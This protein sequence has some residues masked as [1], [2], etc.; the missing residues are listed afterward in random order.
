MCC[1]GRA[2]FAVGLVFS[3]GGIIDS[4]VRIGNALME[5]TRQDALKVFAQEVQILKGQLRFVQLPF[6]EDALDDGVNVR[7]DARGRRIV[8]RAAG[9]LNGVGQH[10]DG[11]F[12]GLRAR[13]HIAEIG[14][15]RLFALVQGLLVEKAYQPCAVVLTD[16]VGNILPELVPLG[17]FRAFFDMEECPAIAAL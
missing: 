12:L 3:P 14:F 10:E 9:C 17:Q 13:P 8:E 1:G 5:N 15:T 6:R 7:L 16:N 2:V 4:G 11:G